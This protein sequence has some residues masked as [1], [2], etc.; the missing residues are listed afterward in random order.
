M[1]VIA[2]RRSR[3]KIVTVRIP[4]T[5]NEELEKLVAAL[6]YPSK[7][8]FI[9]SAIEEFLSEYELNVDMNVKTISNGGDI[10]HESEEVSTL[11]S[12]VLV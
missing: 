7:S 8:E 2:R 11:E 10:H 3:R 4:I 6:K 9:R 12:V 1:S 5:L